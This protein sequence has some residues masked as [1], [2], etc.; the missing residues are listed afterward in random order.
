MNRKGA[1]TVEMVKERVVQTTEE[2]TGALLSNDMII[3]LCGE[4]ALAGSKLN[5][6]LVCDPRK[7]ENGRYREAVSVLQQC[8]GLS[9]P[10]GQGQPYPEAIMDQFSPLEVVQKLESIS[11]ISA[12]KRRY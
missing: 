5:N 3:P 6:C 1:V 10:G 4:W 9:L 2:S 12:L 11:G 8:P 7:E